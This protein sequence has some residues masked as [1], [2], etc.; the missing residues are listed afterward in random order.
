M[1]WCTPL[2]PE[3]G[4]A[5][6]ADLYEFAASLV[7]VKPHLKGERERKTLLWGVLERRG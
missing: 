4:R 2:I 6:Q 5:R 1:S 7:Y 3:L